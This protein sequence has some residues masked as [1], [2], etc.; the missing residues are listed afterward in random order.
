VALGED[1]RTLFLTRSAITTV[2]GAADD[3]RCHQN[4]APE[5]YGGTYLW[6][7]RSQIGREDTLDMAEGDRSFSES[8]DVEA[9]SKIGDE[10]MDLADAILALHAYRGGIGGGT[11]QGIFV[12]E[13]S[14]DYVPRGLMQDEALEYS[15]LQLDLYG[16]AP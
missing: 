15:A 10:A 7:A 8:W 3:A 14:D 2:I 9:I 13:R 6:F 4:R 1:L 5:Q 16:Y 12:I 11:V